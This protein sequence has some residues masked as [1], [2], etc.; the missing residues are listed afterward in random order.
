MARRRERAARQAAQERL[1][2]ATEERGRGLLEASTVVMEQGSGQINRRSAEMQTMGASVEGS[3]QDDFPVD[4]GKR[5]ADELNLDLATRR[6]VNAADLENANEEA[7]EDTTTES[8]DERP[9]H[10]KARK[11]SSASRHDLKT[12]WSG[13]ESA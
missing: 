11:L 8:E 5:R 12:P 1:G 4:K 7:I 6:F 3:T 13:S 2:T 10:K 9:V